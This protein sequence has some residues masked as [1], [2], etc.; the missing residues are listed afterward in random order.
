M[1][2][3]M[4]GSVTLTEGK[5]VP[6]V[7][8]PR[9]RI[10]AERQLNVKITD[11]TSVGEEYVVYLLFLA[12]KRDGAIEGAVSFDEFIDKFLVDYEI[13]TDPES[14]APLD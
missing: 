11:A 12:L 4:K 7:C 2:S 14:A 8:G 9:E 6:V 3:L 5:T 1:S 10:T 13:E